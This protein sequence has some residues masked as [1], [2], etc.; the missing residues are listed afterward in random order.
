M[1]SSLK[2]LQPDGEAGFF[3]Q[4]IGNIKQA[5]GDIADHSGDRGAGDAP[6]E[7]Q[8]H[9]R[10]KDDI[11]H[12]TDH[13]AGH[14]LLGGAFPTQDIAEGG[15]EHDKRCA[16]RDK[17]QVFPRKADGVAAGADQ[18]QDPVHAEDGQYRDD[19]TQAEG[20]V[21]AEGRNI[22]GAL[23]FFLT[24]RAGD[25]GAAAD[26]EQVPE[27]HKDHEYRGGEGDSGHLH[28]VAGLPDKKGV[29]HIVDDDHQHRDH[30]GH[31]HGG[32]SLG[33]GG[34]FKQIFICIH[35]SSSYLKS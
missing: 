34:F 3:L 14:G 5:G 30:G 15:A 25:G 6:A 7:P 32:D 26:T 18:V 9:D 20:C 33:N 28:G 12:G 10:V 27:R 22:F 2:V 21:A 16:D 17:G 4:E 29:G 8:D 1:V 11:G 24:E 23:D 31:R 35:Q 13:I 19:H